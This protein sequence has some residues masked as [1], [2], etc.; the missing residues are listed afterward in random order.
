MWNVPSLHK[1]LGLTDDCTAKQ[2]WSEPKPPGRL[3][4][5]LQLLPCRLSPC[6][7]TQMWVSALNTNQDSE[8]CQDS[9]G[10]LVRTLLFMSCELDTCELADTTLV[11]GGGKPMLTYFSS[12]TQSTSNGVGVSTHCL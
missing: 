9:E 7:W 10:V 6:R 2:S 1:S 3:L 4:S 11:R 8:L 5:Y 12:H